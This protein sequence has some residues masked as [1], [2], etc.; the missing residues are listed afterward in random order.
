MYNLYNKEGNAILTT[1]NIK[2]A[3]NYVDKDGYSMRVGRWA[4]AKD[5][6][7]Y[8]L[9]QCVNK[10][11]EPYNLTFYDV[12]Y[13]GNYQHFTKQ[14]SVKKRLLWGLFSYHG[15]EEEQVPWFK[16][17]TFKTEE[18]YLAWKAFCISTFRKVLGSTK[19]LAEREFLWLDAYCGL[20]QEYIDK[21]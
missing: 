21:N 3:L 10:Q 12:S 17:F 7:Y 19:E 14:V 16:H 4:D 1:D 13:K 6:K 8:V 15:Y 2:E 5:K 11:L 9:W 18:E 20:R